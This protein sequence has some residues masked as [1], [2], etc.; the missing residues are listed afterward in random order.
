MCHAK[1]Q[2]A[3]LPCS[4][5]CASVRC[6]LAWPAALAAACQGL[7]ALLPTSASAYCWDAARTSTVSQALIAQCSPNLH[8][9]EQRKDQTNPKRGSELNQNRPLRGQEEGRASFPMDSKFNSPSK[10]SN[11]RRGR[12]TRRTKQNRRGATGT[13]EPQEL[14]ALLSP[15][16]PH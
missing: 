9:Q 10:N 7:C 3:S 8:A 15:F 4:C 6:L 1:G 12:G 2:I 11:P 5:C 14:A 16:S 13:C